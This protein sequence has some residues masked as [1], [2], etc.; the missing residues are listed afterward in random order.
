MTHS[1]FHRQGSVPAIHSD[2]DEKTVNSIAGGTFQTSPR[3]P[4]CWNSIR[5]AIG[6]GSR[7]MTGGSLSRKACTQRPLMKSATLFYTAT[8]AIQRFNCVIIL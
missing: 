1:P 6:F 8:A 2:S 7:A 4:F 3:R 5:P